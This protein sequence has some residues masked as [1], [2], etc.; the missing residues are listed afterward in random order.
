MIFAG[1]TNFYNKEIL[2]ISHSLPASLSLLSLLLRLPPF[3]HRPWPWKHHQ[4]EQ[5]VSFC[6]TAPKVSAPVFPPPSWT[7]LIIGSPWPCCRCLPSPVFARLFAC[8]FPL[9]FYQI[10]SLETP[11]KSH[12]GLL[13]FSALLALFTLL[14][15]ICLHRITLSWC[16]QR[17]WFPR[18][19][20]P[21]F[22]R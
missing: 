14:T 18:P 5:R 19:S 20:R 15:H 11:L 12:W 16:R 9:I 7:R 3:D 1:R 17:P 13:L 21:I 4:L 8:L 6:V 10:N 2:C 22:V